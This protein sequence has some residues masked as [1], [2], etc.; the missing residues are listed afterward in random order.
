MRARA[1]LACTVLVATAAAA[2]H[3]GQSAADPPPASGCTELGTSC[4]APVPSFLHDVKPLLDRSCNS[5]C[6]APGVGPWPLGAYQ[7]VADWASLIQLDLEACTMPPPDA[8]APLT[9]SE[10]QTVLDWIAC[11]TPADPPNV[12]QAPAPI[13]ASRP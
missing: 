3:C 11:G 6:H 10:R 5:T 2:S 13:Q 1:L 7:D 8:G 9:D 4:N 12:Q